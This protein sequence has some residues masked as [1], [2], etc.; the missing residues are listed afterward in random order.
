MRIVS[1][2]GLTK[3]YGNQRIALSSLSFEVEQ[4]MTLGLL[5]PNGAGKTT[6]IK[7]L[8]G[9][10]LPTSGH[11][12]TFGKRVTPD[13][14]DIRRRIGFLPTNPR[15]PTDLTPITYLDFMGKLSGLPRS[16]RKSRLAGL[17]RAVELLPA[18]AKESKA[19]QPECVPALASPPR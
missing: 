5:G 17:V 14:A 3:I 18:S 1:A 16:A 6:A 7:L 9:L 12:E 11:C 19:F 8:L 4:G 15:F 13:A 10:H 2:H